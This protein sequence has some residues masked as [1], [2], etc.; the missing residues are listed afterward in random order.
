MHSLCD[1]LHEVV[2]LVIGYH[3]FLLLEPLGA[4]D[5]GYVDAGSAVPSSYSRTDK[6]TDFCDLRYTSSGEGDWVGKGVFEGDPIDAI[7]RA[8]NDDVEADTGCAC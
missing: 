3:G 1:V 8:F 6:S 2:E 4:H 7:I 5:D